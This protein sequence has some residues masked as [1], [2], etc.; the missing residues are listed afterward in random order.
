MPV[1]QFLHSFI[2]F[3]KCQKG[4]DDVL[5]HDNSEIQIN[6][7]K[8]TAWI[9]HVI[10]WYARKVYST[11]TYG[12]CE[13]WHTGCRC[14]K[15]KTLALNQGFQSLGSP[16]FLRN[17][18]EAWSL[19]WFH[20]TIWCN[21]CKQP[22]PFAALP[23]FVVATLGRPTAWFWIGIDGWWKHQAILANKSKVKKFPH[24]SRFYLLSQK[25]LTVPQTNTNPHSK[26][27]N[28]GKS[29]F[30]NSEGFYI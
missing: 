8:G 14:H 19:R 5:F 28:L 16:E 6:S 29:M 9:D 10:L 23:M 25:Y 27:N 18:K 22:W 1:L 3:G 21:F 7:Q 11:N 4:L 17:W 26:R 15:G 30:Y 13:W 2:T 24:R 12:W 20:V